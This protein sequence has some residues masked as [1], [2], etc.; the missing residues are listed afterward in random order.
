[1]QLLTITFNLPLP[2]KDIA[3]FR[4]SIARAAGYEED[5]FHNHLKDGKVIYRYPLI[6]YR[7]VQGK[8]VVVAL[9][10]G[11]EPLLKWLSG[12]FGRLYWNEKWHDF[13]ATIS[14]TGHTLIM[15]KQPEAFM[16]SQWLPFRTEKFSEWLSLN[17]LSEQHKF[18]EKLL[19][20]HIL[21]NFCNAIN[22]ELPKGQLVIQIIRF[23]EKKLPFKGKI[24]TGFD[25]D[26]SCNLLL[27]DGI[28]LGQKASHGFGVC[29][30][31]RS[32]KK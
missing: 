1:M 11:I 28:G 30:A 18:L 12:S 4:A 26:F 7:S 8:A 3:G 32:P 27:P 15:F 31:L 14:L 5:L 10:E 24:F 17:S 16:L 6:Q 20:S 23:K 25:L 19:I 22:W 13:T 21:N 29:R 2:R 9:N